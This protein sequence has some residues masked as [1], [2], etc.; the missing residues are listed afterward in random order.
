MREVHE[1]QILVSTQGQGKIDATQERRLQLHGRECCTH[2]GASADAALLP[3][4]SIPTA[5]LHRFSGYL[6]SPDYP[7]DTS[8][9]SGTESSADLVLRILGASPLADPGRS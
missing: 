5:S 3:R 6:P 4:L 2:K 8:A 1:N 7:L 9:L